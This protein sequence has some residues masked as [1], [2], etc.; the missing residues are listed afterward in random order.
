MV[1]GSTFRYGSHF[2]HVTFRPRL[3]SRQPMEAAAIPFP[4]EE[5]T[6]PVTKMYFAMLFSSP[7]IVGQAILSAACKA[8][9]QGRH[10]LQIF[11]RIHPYRFVSRF[12][13]ADL[14]PIFKRAQLLQALSPL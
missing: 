3:S 5:T 14:V 10:S 12:H 1:P 7:H 6:P 13:H 2:W 9:P 4:S 11:R 8:A